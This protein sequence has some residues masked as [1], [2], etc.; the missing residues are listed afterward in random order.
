MVNTEELLKNGIIFDAK[1][2][3]V[4]YNYRISYKVSIICL[5]IYKC[6]GRM[7][8][9]LIKMHIIASALADN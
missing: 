8:C 1:P 3:V 9:S 6:C 2:D 5:L 4:P 7:G